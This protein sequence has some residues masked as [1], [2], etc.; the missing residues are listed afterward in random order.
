V[1]DGEGGTGHGYAKATMTAG[2]AD[3]IPPVTTATSAPPVGATG[4]NTTDVAV[5]LRAIANPEGSA[6]RA[7]T[8]ALSGA[9]PLCVTA[10]GLGRERLG[11]EKVGEASYSVEH[12][13]RPALFAE[14]P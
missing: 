2:S 1:T 7:V 13:N 14:R 11:M 5:D 4:W 6:V 10:K 3:T 9:D 12:S 8:F